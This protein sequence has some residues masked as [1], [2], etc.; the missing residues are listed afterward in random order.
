MVRE[1][2][3]VTAKA[4]G[5]ADVDEVVVIVILTAVL[6]RNYA[7]GQQKIDLDMQVSLE[8]FALQ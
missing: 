3:R 2:A 8:D 6:Q 5:K 7:L 4:M 1:R